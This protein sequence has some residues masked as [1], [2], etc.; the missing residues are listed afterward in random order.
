MLHPPEHLR[1]Q[2]Q[3]LHIPIREMNRRFIEAVVSRMTLRPG[4]SKEKVTPY[5]E[6]I[7]YILRTVVLRYRGEKQIHTLHAM[8]ETA[9][10][11][12]DMVLFGIVRQPEEERA[13]YGVASGKGLEKEEEII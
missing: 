2:I 7:E 5:L 8:L 11:V 9:Q 6:G 10:E 3:R 13:G 1:D 12:L 4:L